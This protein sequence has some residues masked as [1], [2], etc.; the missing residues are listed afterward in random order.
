MSLSKLIN[1]LLGRKPA[2]VVPTAAPLQRQWISNPWHAV[3]IIPSA[4]S[5]RLARSLAN[6]RFLSQQAP[7]LPLADCTVR[8]CTCRYRHFQDRR[9]SSRRDSE[10][11]GSRLGWSGNERRV[12]RGRRS[13]DHA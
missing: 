12:A 4:R 8:P 5:C 1:S 3:S 10:L 13:T 7:I 9:T 11:V 6:V 2:D